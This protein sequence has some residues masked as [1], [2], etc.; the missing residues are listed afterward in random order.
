MESSHCPNVIDEALSGDYNDCAERAKQILPADVLAAITEEQCNNLKNNT[1]IYGTADDNCEDFQGL[2][3]DIRQDLEAVLRN[4]AMTIFANDFSKC[5]DTDENPT[6]ASMWSRIYRFAQAVTCVFCAYD[7]FMT[8]LLK[9]GKYPQ[10]L[11]GAPTKT[12]TEEELGCSLVGYPVWVEPDKYPTDG[13]TRPVTSDGVFEAIEDAILSVWHIWKAHPE[14]AYYAE[15]ENKGDY[16]L[17]SIKDAEEYDWCL[18]KENAAGEYNVLY[19]WYDD[20]W[21]KKEVLGLRGEKEDQ[22]EKEKLTNFSVTHI[23]KGYWAD[24]GLYY[25]ETNNIPS[26]NIMDANLTELEKRVRAVEDIYSKAVLSHPSEDQRF[27]ITTK[28][29]LT[30]ANKVAATADKTTLVFIVGG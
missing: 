13:S 3:C 6:L 23:K 30:E 29:N 19:Q 27:L 1:G 14:F 22:A 4:E 26:W 12:M 15:F 21:N 17:N 10:I 24:K 25:F 28:A 11:M 7:P 9:S 2:L 18:V 8:T 5:S 16:P 20:Q